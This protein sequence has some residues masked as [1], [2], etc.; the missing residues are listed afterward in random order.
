MFLLFILIFI[1]SVAV[2]H[3]IPGMF[4]FD[5]IHFAIVDK[6]KQK[7]MYYFWRYS[8]LLPKS[9]KEI[10]KNRIKKVWGKYPHTL[11]LRI[12]FN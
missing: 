8:W 3:P 1:V 4:V 7:A 9:N 12:I 10:L 6:N 11:K 5:K 2:L